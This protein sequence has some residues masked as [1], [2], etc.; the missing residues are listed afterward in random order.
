MCCEELHAVL[1][2]VLQAGNIL[3][4]GGY[5]GNAVGFKLSSLLSLADTKANKPGMNL[6]HFEAQKKDT[7]LLEFPQKLHHV[8][9]AARISLETLDAELQFQTSRT[10]SVEENIER[11]THLLKQL[12]SFLQ[13]KQEGSDL[14]DFFCEDRE[15]FRLDDCFNIFNSFCCRFTQAAKENAERESKEAL[16]RRR[17][18]DLEEQKRHSWAGGEEVGG[19]FGL[20]CSSETD[21]SSAVSRHDNAGLLLD[22]LTLRSRPRS[23]LNNSQN[24]LRRSGSLRRSRNSPSSSPFL[25]ADRELSTLLGMTNERK[26]AAFPSV[27]PEIRSPGFSLKTSNF[28]QT[29]SSP[30]KSAQNGNYTTANYLSFDSTQTRVNKVESTSDPNQQSDHNN[31][32]GKHR[33]VL[34]AHSEF[35]GG[36]QGE[37]AK[38]ELDFPDHSDEKFER[39][40]ANMS[41]VLEKCKLVPELRVF[42]T[43]TQINTSG[44]QD[45]MI[46]DQKNSQKLENSSLQREEEEGREDTVVVWCVTGVCEA[47]DEPTNAENAQ[48]DQSRS[49]KQP[50]SYPANRTPS[51]SQ[52]ANEK[53]VPEPISSQPVPA[54][55][56]ASSPRWR[57]TDS[58]NNK[59]PA[60][61]EVANEKRKVESKANSGKAESGNYS[62]NKNLPTSKTRPIGIKQTT[63]SNKSNP[64]RTLTNSENISMRRVVPI[65]RTKRQEKP[66]SSTNLKSSS[67]WKPSTAPS[68]RRTSVDQKDQKVSR[69]LQNQDLQRKPSNLTNIKSSSFRKPSTAPSS[70]RTSVDQ[71]DHKDHKVSRDPQNLP[72]KQP[73]IRK[74]LA[75]PKAPP[76]EKMCRS[77]LRAL[78]Q[79]SGSISA[80]VT[81]LHKPATSSSTSSST[82][83]AGFA[84]N[85]ASSSFRQTPSPSPFSRTGSLRVSAT[86]GSSDSFKPPSSSSPL[87]RFQS[88]RTPI[89]DSV[90]PP[91]GHRRND[92]GT[93]SEKSTYSRDSGKSSKPTWR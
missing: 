75:K 47:A 80:P 7:K 25:T 5:A 81:P 34:G 59:V 26:E 32:N 88:I 21:M 37:L 77:T 30:P 91:K 61:E 2:L 69:D 22:L 68:S 48:T 85:T 92:S 43:V 72:R 35:R 28:P 52:S 10:R 64:V 70:R 20:R 87:K 36:F 45:D 41:V 90:S 16:R 50:S 67:F 23:P 54:S 15:T 19:A 49:D 9:P 78:S 14:L 62:S 51:E 83:F 63:N 66:S 46:P 89:C 53:P 33:Q 65:S 4:A 13:L 3:N 76:E 38:N 71:K 86:S 39:S 24:A 93:F 73:S 84:R 42:D 6:L 40:L 8:Q 29:A 27:F 79:A 44:V 82:P 60:I 74:P 1:H 57:P 11:D 58:A 18:Q 56:P 55:H 12:D 31:N 17:L